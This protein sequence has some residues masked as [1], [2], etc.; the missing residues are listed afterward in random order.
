M[1]KSANSSAAD[2][3]TSPCLN[4]LDICGYNY[5]SGRYPLEGEKHPDRIIVGSETF[6]QDI[7]KNWE[8][9]KKLPY[10][11]G[12]FVWTA[13]DYLGE[14]GL[15]SWAFTPDGKGFNKPYPWLLAEA[16]M[17]DIL[18]EP[19][20]EVFLAQ[21]VWGLLQKPQIAVQPVNHNN[22]TPAKMVWRGTN[23]IPS[24]SFKGCDGNRAT[25][26]VYSDAYSTELFLNNKS[27]GKKRIKEY[28]AVFVTK[29][30][31]GELKAVC[32][33]KDSNIISEN[34]LHSASGKLKIRITA[35]T[36][37]EICYAKI[38]IV[39]ENGV[40]ESNADIKLNVM[41]EDGELLAFG[42]ANPRTEDNYLKGEFT[43][44][45]GKAQ[46]VIRRKG[47]AR[48]TMTVSGG[49]EISG[50]EVIL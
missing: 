36:S 13:W 27:I 4:L 34:A 15:G 39:G 37:S 38:E 2:S 11:I 35:E 41:V 17:F 3:V 31:S 28:K 1:N 48:A 50:T 22:K 26:E 5:A 25:V 49:A 45:Y 23:S 33:D 10:L 19:T 7:A 47:S 40:I 6:P 44:Y 30:V 46:A 29:Y 12:D 21:A 42:S 8:M 9:V 18:G 14:A 20:G 43:T 24:W 32:Y 16:G